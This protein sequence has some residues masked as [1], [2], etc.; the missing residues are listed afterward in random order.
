MGPKQRQKESLRK[1]A[2]RFIVNTIYLLYWSYSFAVGTIFGILVAA[3]VPLLIE[4]VGSMYHAGDL[5]ATGEPLSRWL[6]MSGYWLLLLAFALH[7]VEELRKREREKYNLAFRLGVLYEYVQTARLQGQSPSVQA[8]LEQVHAIFEPLHIAHV[9]IHRKKDGVICIESDEV[10]PQPAVPE[11]LVP[12][13]EGKGVA[14]RVFGDSVT[15]YVPRIYLPNKRKWLPGIFMPHA[16]RLHF[17]TVDVDGRRVASALGTIGMDVNV[18]EPPANG[19]LL[20]R[21]FL[22]L[23]VRDGMNGQCVAVLSLDFNSSNSLKKGDIALAY[24]M[25]SSI[26]AGIVKSA[27]QAPVGASK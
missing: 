8:I 15:R 19:N 26:A 25:A 22:S 21:S 6:L 3:F 11:F 10:F 23:P 27:P 24:E 20:F 4:F 16:L 1:S 14:G 17:E 18:T 9:A 7:H 2:V 12:F 5:P 13:H